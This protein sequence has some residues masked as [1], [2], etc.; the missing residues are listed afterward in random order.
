MRLAKG[1]SNSFIPCVHTVLTI[2]ENFPDYPQRTPS[3]KKC[4]DKQQ[5]RYQISWPLHELLDPAPAI[6][7]TILSCDINTRPMSV[8]FP[9]KSI[10]TWLQ[11]ESMQIK[12]SKE[13]VYVSYM[14]TL[15]VSC[16]NPIYKWLNPP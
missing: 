5:V 4:T 12:L 7:L 3:M 14:N 15:H 11:N 10:C 2:I 8:Q 13:Y 9:Q 16:T 6:I 1:L